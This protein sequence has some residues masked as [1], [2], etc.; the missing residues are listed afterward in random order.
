MIR[1]PMILERGCSTA[2]PELCCDQM[3]VQVGRLTMRIEREMEGAARLDKSG[4][5]AVDNRSARRQ[6]W[7]SCETLYPA[8]Y[9]KLSDSPSVAQSTLPSPKNE[10]TSNS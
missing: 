5:G 9:R 3:E 4:E 1:W 8:P 6:S 2:K 7:T 10:H